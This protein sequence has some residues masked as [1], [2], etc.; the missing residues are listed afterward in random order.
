MNYNIK[1][2]SEKTL[3]QSWNVYGRKTLKQNWK[4][5]GR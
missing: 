5:Y 2:F 3:E 1:N 4:I